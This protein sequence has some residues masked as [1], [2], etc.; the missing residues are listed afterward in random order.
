MRTPSLRALTGATRVLVV[1]IVFVVGVGVGG[2]AVRRPLE[3]KADL[4]LFWQA[5]GIVDRLFYGDTSTEARV[6][7]AIAG[8]VAGLG[9]P[10]TQYLPPDDNER[11]QEDLT[12][13]FGGIGAE[14]TVKDG[15]ITVVSA[16]RESPAEAAGLQAGD[17]LVKIG[18]EDATVMSLSQAIELIRGDVGSQVQLTVAR[19]GASQPVV[20]TITRDTIVV[21]SVEHE[22]VG[23]TRFIT[24][25]QFGADTVEL[26]EAALE[27]ANR[28]GN[29]AVVVDLR[30]N[31]GGYLD[32]AT[33]MLGMVLPEKGQ[34]SGELRDRVAVIERGKDGEDER[35]IAKGKQVW[36]G[37]LVVLI[38]KG[39]ASASEIFAG[40]V[41]DY[42]RGQVVGTKSFGKGSV[43]QL[44]PL[45]NGGSL[46]IT[47]ANW[48]TP[49][50]TSIT[51][52]G[53]LPDTEV[54]LGAEESLGVEDSQARKAL[55]LAAQP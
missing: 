53:V 44:E 43:Q 12:G 9:D 48:Y 18:E 50:G 35:L 28:A 33:K 7:G 16:L 40:A 19:E 4:S 22:Q 55:E 21:E 27:E 34:L 8:M 24:V 17:I 37:K 36:K 3:E 32:G 6:D 30:N 39:S 31:P 51:D 15:L 23:N 1:L 11:F 25:N 5:W 54:T 46:K 47:V 20:V 42:G 26:F 2:L 41:K 14:L 52:S 13:E 38:N 49:L 45:P 10:Y 29:Q